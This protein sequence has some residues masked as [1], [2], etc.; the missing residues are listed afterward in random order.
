[1]VAQAANKQVQA[2]GLPHRRIRFVT[3]YMQAPAN[4]GPS[5]A[6]RADRQDLG[7]GKMTE[8]GIL[9]LADTGR[10]VVP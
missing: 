10:P 8:S 2:T 3:Q 9:I 7:L 5:P 1:M 4:C 6:S